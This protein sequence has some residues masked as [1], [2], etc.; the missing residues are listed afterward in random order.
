[1]FL[2]WKDG[3]R[4]H[5]ILDEVKAEIARKTSGEARK[6]QAALLKRS[7]CKESKTAGKTSPSRCDGGDAR[8]KTHLRSKHRV[9]YAL[10]VDARRTSKSFMPKKSQVN[11]KAES[12]IRRR[13]GGGGG[14]STGNHAQ[15]NADTF[16]RRFVER[17]IRGREA[18]LADGRAT[19]FCRRPNAE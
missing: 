11:P 4:L 16:T 12:E 2:F 15:I 7:S 9:E 10:P 19:A 17:K 6:R 5:E 8:C 13:S 3:A 1:M 18:L 14:V